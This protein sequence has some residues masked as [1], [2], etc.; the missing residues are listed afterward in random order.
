MSPELQAVIDEFGLPE[1]PKSSPVAKA[2]VIDWA[3]SDDI[4]TL[5]ALY[6]FLMKSNYAARVQP[7]L[8]FRELWSFLARYY[9]RCFRED[10]NG[11]WAN[12]RYPAAWDFA[13]WFARQTKTSTVD[14]TELGR[15]KDW[16]GGIYKS[17][18]EP[19]RRC[20]V[21][22][23]LEHLFENRDIVK[24]FSDWK[25]DPQLAVAYTEA[26]E[27]ADKGGKTDLTSTP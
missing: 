15:V 18:D 20:I 27:W 19:L 3:K 25:S 2:R 8:T 22:G 23:A 16:L 9:E 5:G 7:P 24:L 21:D 1:H 6:A 17:A 11:N 12:G 10:P 26:R 13:S 14:R 4:E